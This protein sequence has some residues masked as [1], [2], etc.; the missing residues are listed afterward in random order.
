MKKNRLLNKVAEGI[1]TQRE[2][3]LL[4]KGFD[5]V[6]DI[7][8][9]KVP[10]AL[11][12]KKL[13]FADALL[14]EVGP[15]IKVILGQTSP[16]QGDYRIRDLE[17]LA[18]EMRTTTIHKEHG[19]NLSVDLAKVY[20]S[21][22]LSYERLRIAK[23]I[24]QSSRQ[25]TIINMFAGVGSFSIVIAT[26]YQL[27]KIYS[28]DI[29]PEAVRFMEKNIQANKVSDKVIPILGDARTVI[30]EKLQKVANRILMPL[31]EKAYEYLDAAVSALNLGTGFIHYYNIIHAKKG[32]KPVNLITRKVDELMRELG[33]DY[34]LISSRVVRTI[35]PNWHQV[36][37]DMKVPSK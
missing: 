22:R 20:F 27:V 25:E 36:V 6:G 1:L 24:Q 2:M 12:G 14:Q 31:P 23:L 17:W 10:N 26:H 34:E 30:K 13:K 15:R 32:E 21:P 11:E 37:L 28:I 19:C 3:Q 7:G 4:G 5:I 16:V 8:I 33:T 9:I 35:G 29:N 18:G